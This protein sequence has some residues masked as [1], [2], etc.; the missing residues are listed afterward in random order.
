MEFKKQIAEKQPNL[1]VEL[2]L[3][4]LDGKAQTFS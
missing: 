1:K 3:T 2:G 4:A